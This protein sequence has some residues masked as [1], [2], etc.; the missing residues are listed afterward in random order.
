MT[1]IGQVFVELL[2][3]NFAGKRRL[4]NSD[5]ASSVFKHLFLTVKL[6]GLDSLL[7]QARFKQSFVHWSQKIRPLSIS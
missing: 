4:P 7:F 6:C 1:I 3:T 2:R 5:D